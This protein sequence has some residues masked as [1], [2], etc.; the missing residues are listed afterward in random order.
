[1]KSVKLVPHDSV[2][3]QESIEMDEYSDDDDEVFLQNS[4]NGRETSDSAR[5]P[6]MKKKKKAK[7]GDLH[8]TIRTSKPKYRRCCGPLC[9]MFLIFKLL[10][11]K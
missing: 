1:M 5:R 3:S 4:R 2:D 9:I 8:T 11:G 7:N 10:I 6:L